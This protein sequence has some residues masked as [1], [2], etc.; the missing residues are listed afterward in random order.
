MAVW[1]ACMARGNGLCE[2]MTSN[3]GA[4]AWEDAPRTWH[5][6][7]SSSSRDGTSYGLLQAP[8]SEICGARASPAVCGA[9]ALRCIAHRK[10]QIANRASRIAQRKSR[11][12]HR[13]DPLGGVPC[14][15]ARPCL[16]EGGSRTSRLAKAWAQLSRAGVVK[17]IRMRRTQP[18]TQPGRGRR[19][20]P[21]RKPRT[22]GAGFCRCF[23]AHKQP[24]HRL[25]DVISS[26]TR[27]SPVARTPSP[28][29]KRSNHPHAVGR[30][31]A[32]ESC[33]SVRWTAR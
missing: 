33:G 26:C 5:G 8:R 2:L 15:D 24:N 20:A 25:S 31:K 16:R 21:P 9:A 7:A 27:P 19:R 4:H 28:A 18:Q 29:P 32:P 13:S 3:H 11:I 1:C 6:T 30:P 14:D 23:A 22:R 17:P 12:A 10:S